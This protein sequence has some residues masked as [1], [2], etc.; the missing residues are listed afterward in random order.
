[1]GPSPPVNEATD[2]SITVFTGTGSSDLDASTVERIENN[3]ECKYACIT[4]TLD[5]LTYISST[6]KTQV[7]YSLVISFIDTM[8]IVD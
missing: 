5:H 2:S 3:Y 6:A 1:L 8:S 7:A 4:P